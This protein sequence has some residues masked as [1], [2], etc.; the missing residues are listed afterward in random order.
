MAQLG[1][2]TLRS[3]RNKMRNTAPFCHYTF[4]LS[5][6]PRMFHNVYQHI[7]DFRLLNKSPWNIAKRAWN[8][9]FHGMFHGPIA[10]FHGAVFPRFVNT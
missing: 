1:R 9:M 8:I 3:L 6:V 5:S 4:S 10:S 7:N 2:G